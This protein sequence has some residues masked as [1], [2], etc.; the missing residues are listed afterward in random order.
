[1]KNTRKEILLEVTKS[2]DLV[3]RPYFPLILCFFDRFFFEFGN[4]RFRGNYTERNSVFGFVVSPEVLCKETSSDLSDL[5]EA[6]VSEYPINPL[7]C[8]ELGLVC[9]TCDPIVGVIPVFIVVDLTFVVVPVIVYVILCVP[10]SVPVVFSNL[11]LRG[12]RLVLEFCWV[13]DGKGYN[14]IVAIKVDVKRGAGR[15]CPDNEEGKKQEENGNQVTKSN[16]IL[17]HVC[18][19]TVQV[20]CFLRRRDVFKIR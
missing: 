7:R 16:E 20:L 6:D 3:I 19:R 10:I 8:V 11:F 5:V 9:Q 4:V 13:I 12:T 18:L 17:A 1:M 15:D 14:H 2:E